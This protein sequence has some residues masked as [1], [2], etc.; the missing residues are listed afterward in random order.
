MICS[1][2][3]FFI[4][5]PDPNLDPDTDPDL[6]GKKKIFGS[7]TLLI[8]VYDKN[9]IFPG[10]LIGVMSW[11]SLRTAVRLRRHTTTAVGT[12]TSMWG[13]CAQLT[14]SGIRKGKEK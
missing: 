14:C 4:N 10:T 6:K 3:V 9:L 12:C 13:Y 5:N 11:P 8:S 7:T 1:S 2:N